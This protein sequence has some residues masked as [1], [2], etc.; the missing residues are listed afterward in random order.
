MDSYRNTFFLNNY[1]VKRIQLERLSSCDVSLFVNEAHSASWCHFS[2]STTSGRG[3][4]IVDLFHTRLVHCY[5]T[6][7]EIVRNWWD[8]IERVLLEYQ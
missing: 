3:I 2:V 5:N 8:E 1:N 7:Y 6:N 4:L